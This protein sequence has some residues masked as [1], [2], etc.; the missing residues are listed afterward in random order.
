M[1]RLKTI[2]FIFSCSILFIHSKAFAG[3]YHP[4]V[5]S[6]T[7]YWNVTDID[8]S[9]GG[10]QGTFQNYLHVFL[11]A[12]DSSYNGKLCKKIFVVGNSKT[13]LTLIGFMRE[14]NEQVFFKSVDATKDT[15]EK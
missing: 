1:K 11:M 13:D 6:D 15:T 14:N 7:V 5:V 2:I 12:G 9:G 3:S 4:F 8:Q 10:G